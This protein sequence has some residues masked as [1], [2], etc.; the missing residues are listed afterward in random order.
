VA[1]SNKGLCKE[2]IGLLE[3]EDRSKPMSQN[4]QLKAYASGLGDYVYTSADQALAGTIIA[5]GLK[6]GAARE[7]TNA[8]FAF[9]QKLGT[10]SMETD[11]SANEFRFDL[12]WRT[13]K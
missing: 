8:L 2:L 12:H 7:Q 13:K 1:A 4:M 3:K 9:L 5:Q 11:Y 6:V 10:V